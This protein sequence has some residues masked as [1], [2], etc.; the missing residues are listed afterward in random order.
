M[1]MCMCTLHLYPKSKGLMS[2]EGNPLAMYP[3]G[4]GVLPAVRESGFKE[5]P[6]TGLQRIL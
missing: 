2:H 3:D 5:P 1:C 4:F 6:D